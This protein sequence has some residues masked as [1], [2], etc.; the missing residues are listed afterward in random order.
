MPEDEDRR[1]V[2]ALARPLRNARDLDPLLERIGDARIVAVGEASHGTHEYYA[3][4]AAL[5]RR[6]IEE[7]GF[8]VVAVE[9]DWP[10][11][12]RVNRS[13]RLLPGADE[14][15]RDALDAFARWPTWMWA[16]DDVV[17]FCR[18]LRRYNAD[19][20]DGDRVGFYGL[21]VYSLW[22][23]MHELIGWLEQNEPG[24][25]ARARRALACFEPYGEDGAEY[26]FAHRFSPTS[27][28]DAAVEV[29]RA[30][31]EDRGRAEAEEDPE[32]RFAAEQNAAVVVDAERYYRAMVQGSAESWNVRD[33]HMVDVLDRLLEHTG[34]KVVVWEHNTHIGDAR[35]TDMAGGGMVNVGQ[36]LRERHGTD[37]VV[38]VGFG[39]HRGGVIAGAE[40][41][42]QMARM[43]VPPVRAGSLEALLHDAVG[44]D[45][46]VVV[47][48]GERPG[49][50]DRR[51]DHRAIGVVYRPERERWGNYVPTVLGERYDAFLHLE[52][53]S[54]LQPLHLER[55][56]EHVPLAS[57]GV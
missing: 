27:C 32:A 51:L 1:Q 30:L 19:R 33:V 14:D 36:L 29:L 47:P 50:L 44:E 6:L 22:D 35:A 11:C 42:A 20:S 49:W 16:N 55:P 38:L 7:R 21:D 15:P 39:G 43:S 48:G 40:W 12:Y 31:C 52:H 3:W 13:V 10:D 46:L 34:G 18:W 45:S 53:T 5:T 23:S 17:D 57:E 2:R 56:D 25:V 9:G 26:A 41:G 28:E 4:R 37:D 24:H 54:P 8:A